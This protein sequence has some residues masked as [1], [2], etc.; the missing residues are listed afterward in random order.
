M[1]NVKNYKEQGADK[2]VIGGTLEIAEDGQ[3]NIE[4]EPFTRA[5]SQADSTAADV[6]G[7]VSDFNS[8]LAKLR[9]AG[10]IAED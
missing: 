7:L 6:A 2:W 5:D 3:I 4:G 8:L 1:S 9:T 10:L